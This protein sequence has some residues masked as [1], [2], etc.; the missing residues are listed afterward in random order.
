MT[1]IRIICTHDASKLA[2]TLTRLLEAEEHRVRV[3][4]GR[5]AMRELETAQESK[6][7]VVLIW[8]PD[9][10]SQTYMLEWARQIPPPRLIDITLTEDWPRLGRKATAIDFSQWRGERSERAAW[11]ALMDRLRGV[12]RA[13]NP[14]K[15]PSKYAA[16]ALGMASAA[17]MTGAVVLRMSETTTAPMASEDVAAA[18]LDASDPQTGLG[19]PVLAVEP[20]SLEDFAPIRVR[21]FPVAPHIEL[22]AD[23]PLAALPEIEP[24]EIRDAT[25]LERLTALNPLRSTGDESES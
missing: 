20:A 9:A 1:D 12:A 18:P 5:Q 24:M 2:E 19:G 14:P 21:N 15:P 16:L 23:V 6:D 3:T 17:A 25:L 13:L 22:A 8:S 11:N 4:M 7:A 10:R